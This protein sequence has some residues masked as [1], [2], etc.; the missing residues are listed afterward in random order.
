MV[1]MSGRDE[2]AYDGELDM[3]RGLVRTIGVV[4][5]DDGSAEKHRA[6]VRQ[7]LHEHATDEA[8]AREA[9]E[10]SSRPAVDATPEYSQARYERY[11]TALNNADNYAQLTLRDDRVRFARAAM[12]AADEEL[13]PVYSNA[14]ATGRQH[15]GADGWALGFFTPVFTTSDGTDCTVSELRHQ[16]CS[17]LVQG[18]GPLTLIDLMA[19]A[20]RHTCQQTTGKDGRS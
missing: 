2:Q 15:A 13:D 4:V 19:L 20:S 7:L 14:Y 1:G 3:L 17:G 12:A 18:V 9:Q 16:P 8:A 11:I 10:K 5:R 6:E